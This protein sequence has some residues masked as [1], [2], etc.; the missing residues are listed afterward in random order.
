MAWHNY[1]LTMWIISCI[2]SASLKQLNLIT[3]TKFFSIIIKYWA[4]KVATCLKKFHKSMQSKEMAKSA[5]SRLKQMHK[6]YSKVSSVL[7]TAQCVDSFR[8]L[9][10]HEWLCNWPPGYY[11]WPI[12]LFIQHWNKVVVDVSKSSMEVVLF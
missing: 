9:S 10:Q 4:H 2:S 1:S 11:E 3:L 8:W 7:I 5:P 6:R 12:S